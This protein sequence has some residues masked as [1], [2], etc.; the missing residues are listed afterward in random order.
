MKQG[1]IIVL[2]MS[3]LL[4]SATASA[5]KFNIP[6]QSVELKI[7]QPITSNFNLNEK[8]KYSLAHQLITTKTLDAKR[9]L[10][11]TRPQITITSLLEPIVRLENN[12]PVVFDY[13]FIQGAGGQVTYRANIDFNINVIV[14]NQLTANFLV[15]SPTNT[16]LYAVPIQNPIR[17]LNQVQL[18]F[19]SEIPGYE[20]GIP[21]T[22]KIQVCNANNCAISNAFQVTPGRVY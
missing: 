18:E 9:L 13:H 21:A 10:L 19:L 2:L 7:T 17:G 16:L 22:G 20:R 1:A 3:I 4:V 6:S 14:E 5:V 8:P 12:N 11:I 15:Y